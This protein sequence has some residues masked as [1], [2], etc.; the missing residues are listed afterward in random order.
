MSIIGKI[1]MTSF[2]N[3]FKNVSQNVFFLSSNGWLKRH[4]VK[5]SWRMEKAERVDTQKCFECPYLMFT[6]AHKF[7]HCKNIRCLIFFNQIFRGKQITFRLCYNEL[8]R[9]SK[10]CLFYPWIVITT[11]INVISCHLGS[12]L[13]Q[14]SLL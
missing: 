6:F 3:D 13:G 7:L 5:E 14:F 8:H 9:T 12:K 1:F 10:K 11:K 4:F 2:M